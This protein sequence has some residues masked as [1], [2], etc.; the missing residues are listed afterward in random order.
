M[1]LLIE[2]TG[3]NIEKFETFYWKNLPESICFNGQVLSGSTEIAENFNRYF[4]DSVLI[5]IF[6]MKNKLMLGY[7]CEKLV[8]MCNSFQDKCKFKANCKTV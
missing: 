3:S 8:D 5:T 6:K 2:I 4:I 1:N 7:F